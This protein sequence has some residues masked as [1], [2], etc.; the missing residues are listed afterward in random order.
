MKTLFL[1]LLVFTFINIHR[2]P[3][4]ES[5]VDTS[6]IMILRIDPKTANG[7]SMSRLFEQ[8]DFV[9]L[10]TT[11][12]SL[13]G[14][15]SQ[16]EVTDDEFIIFDND[17]KCILIFDKLGKYKNKINLV[18]EV[19]GKINTQDVDIN[20]FTLKSE[21]TTQLIVAS[22]R[23]KTFVFNTKAERVD[24]YERSD[25]YY[26]T[27]EYLFKDL[28]RVFSYYKNNK[29]DDKSFY[30]YVL[31][32]DDKTVGKYFEIDTGKLSKNGDFAVGGPSLI[33]TDNSEIIHAVKYYDYNI[34]RI[35][36][37]GISVAYR[38]VFPK[39][40]SIPNDFNTN[41]IYFGKK[42][43][44]FFKYPK[45]IF[46]IGYTYKIGN[47]LYFKCGGLSSDIRNNGSFVYN[48]ANNYLIS[49]NRL[50]IDDT[51]SYLPIMGRWD[52][53]IKKY[54]GEYLYCSLSSLEMF[55]FYEQEK[56][57][58]RK[59]PVVMNAYF[60]NGNNKDNPVIIRIKPK[61]DI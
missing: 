43:D 42:I 29:H 46:G 28:T 38:L 8:I 47:N 15:I 1:S 50:D 17:T 13:F 7:G 30:Q 51:S 52:N 18:K 10:E 21:N 56:D 49:L 32:K 45:K 40:N 23:N 14:D 27:Q 60:K 35:T 20:G 48:L 61:K 55:N 58:N 3:C 6:D 54:D 12:E 34:Y 2:A 59:Y 33:E 37:S 5:C 25:D 57:K 39:E 26:A 11:K 53:N 4:Q 16:L 22:T 19:G 36:K 31:T 44:Y 41:N 9:P 24:A